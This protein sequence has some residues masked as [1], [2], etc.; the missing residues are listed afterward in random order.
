[1]SRRIAW[2]V[3]D[4][5]ETLVDET[6]SWDRWADYLRVP[7][8][9]FH[10]TMGAVIAAGRP[11]TDVF[12]FFRSDFD[13]EAQTVARQATGL[14]WPMSDEDLYDDVIP[15]LQLLCARGYQLAVFANQP[16]SAARFM[17]TLPV[18]R[19]AT[20]DQWGIAKPDPR[21]FER[22]AT[23]LETAP[24]QIAYVGDRVDNDVVPAVRAGMLA[25]HLRRGPWGFIQAS[26]PEASQAAI[27]IESLTELAPALEGWQR[28]V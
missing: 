14:G 24:Q 3:F 11:H 21:F 18:D 9:T 23:T 22:I 15:T 25:I 1:V 28:T 8:F 26:W 19:V 2:V 4:L 10:A 6:A 5:G 20:S 13:L 7:R 12:S 16:R 27:R 17:A